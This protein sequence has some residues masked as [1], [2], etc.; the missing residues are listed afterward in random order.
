ME[1]AVT[2]H[3]DL[4]CG[5]KP[6]NPY[7]ADELHALDIRLPE[8]LDAARFR[9]ANLVLEPIPFADDHFDSVSAYDFIEHVPRLV[10]LPQGGT[11]L[12]FVELMNEVWRVLRPGGRF[13]AVTPAW[14]KAEA[15]VDP[16]HVNIITERTHRY[17]CEPDVG[18]DVYGF[19]GRFRALRVQWIRKRVAYEPVTPDFA[20]RVR[21]LV[22]VLK[23]RR[24]HL[25]WELEALKRH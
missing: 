6:R 25:L 9:Q 1:D 13:Y 16:T 11:R 21:T 3:L 4:G 5:P 20:Q 19:K 23:G 10:A 2:R 22:D 8:G 7:S 18:A 15:F 12:P 24:V 17:F 14:P